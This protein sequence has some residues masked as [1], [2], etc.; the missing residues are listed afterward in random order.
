MIC[1]TSRAT[2]W[3]PEGVSPY[4]LGW[5]ILSFRI[6]S[7]STMQSVMSPL[8]TSK[9]SAVP[10]RSTRTSSHTLKRWAR[11]TRAGVTRAGVTR[12]AAAA[13][14][15]MKL[16][17]APVKS[18]ERALYIIPCLWNPGCSYTLKNL[19]TVIL[20]MYLMKATNGM[21]LNQASL[22]GCARSSDCLQPTYSIDVADEWDEC[23]I[24]L[25]E[26]LCCWLLSRSRTS[27]RVGS[28]ALNLAALART[29]NP[30]TSK[31]PHLFVHEEG[32][33]GFWLRT[34]E[35]RIAQMP[36]KVRQSVTCWPT[37]D[38]Y[39]RTRHRTKQC[40]WPRSIMTYLL[41]WPT[42]P[43]WQ[44]STR[45]SHAHCASFRSRESPPSEKRSVGCETYFLTERGFKWVSD[46]SSRS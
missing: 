8:K 21:S 41:T 34:N 29:W 25:T 27:G 24:V 18:E 19:Q 10:R 26:W 23:R 9:V 20:V 5:C 39:L 17:T 7:S 11:V 32:K 31:L 16:R 38:E 6:T 37:H 30:Q 33:G 13:T 3:W 44:R 43:H 1:G 45:T 22:L 15:L 42:G 12:T 4:L 46:I 28:R 40:N 2:I 36:R 35:R 14:W